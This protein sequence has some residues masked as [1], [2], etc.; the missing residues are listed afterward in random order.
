M[1]AQKAIVNDEVREAEFSDDD[2]YRYRLDIRW[3]ADLPT[4]TTIGLNP[5]TATHLHDDPTIRR[6]KS[7]AR[8]MGFGTYRMLNA[9]AYRSTDYK[10]LFRVKDPI[11]PDNTLEYMK[12]WCENSFVLA[13]WGTHITEDGWRHYYRG[14][15]IAESI[16]DLHCLRVTKNGHPEH[17]LYLPSILR[18]IPF[19]YVK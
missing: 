6:C 15:D 7:L 17:P 14:K 16:P 11:G 3:N 9:F 2:I 10:A 5:S 4:L 19:S 12:R 13:C 8:E 18:P 1:I